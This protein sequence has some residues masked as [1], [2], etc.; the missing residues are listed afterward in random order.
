VS[1]YKEHEEQKSLFEWALFRS[2]KW[3]E[4]ESM[5]AIPNA[6]KRTRR[7]GGRLKA[8]GLKVGMPDVCLPVARGNFHGLYIELKVGDNKPTKAQYEWIVR[9]CAQGYLA[10]W[11]VGWQQAASLIEHYMEGK[12][13]V[14]K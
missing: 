5:Y 10:K 6:G 2:N 12:L 11:C 13:E 7:A 3:P 8:E 14:R 4:L 9:L 1:R